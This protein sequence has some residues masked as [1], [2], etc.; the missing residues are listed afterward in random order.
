MFSINDPRLIGAGAAL[1]EAKAL[2][3][4]ALAHAIA[5]SAEKLRKMTMDPRRARRL[6]RLLIAARTLGADRRIGPRLPYRARVSVETQGVIIESRSFDIGKQGIMI[7]RA[8]GW[9]LVDGDRG[10]VKLSLHGVGDFSARV[11]A[12]DADSVSLALQGP[13]S[14]SSDERLT[15]LLLMLDRDNV[16]AI[17]TARHFAHDI[18]SAF[19]ACVERRQ[20]TMAE[21]C[22][23]EL[24]RL[25]GSDPAQFSHPAGPVFAA[26]LPPVMNRYCKP[27]ARI[28]YAVATDRSCY[29]PVHHSRF[30]QAQRPGDLAF[31]HAFARDRRIYDDRWTLRAAIFA[32]GPVVQAYR[33]D[34]P[35]GAGEIVREVSAPIVVSGRRWGAA[36][37]GYLMDEAG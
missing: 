20:A 37:I 32:Q 27:D 17:S 28:V 29:V 2:K 22:S 36:Q 3:D 35:T 16:A 1:G 12:L 25:A 6:E 5:S 13:L 11:V 30:S 31:N 10:A 33:R 14:P 4:P 23:G 21:L 26:I 8:A 9:P 24:D 19:L 7:E 18:A 15:Q 34:V